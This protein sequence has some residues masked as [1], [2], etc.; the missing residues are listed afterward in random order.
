M[1]Q[2]INELK[3]QITYCEKRS[4]D[5]NNDFAEFFRG[6]KLGLEIGLLSLENY[7]EKNNGK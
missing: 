5:P 3:E 2:F 6:K 1:E 4:K 7:K